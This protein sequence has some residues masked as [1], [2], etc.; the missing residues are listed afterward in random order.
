MAPERLGDCLKN[1][2][3]M[4]NN[5]CE[6]ADSPQFSFPMFSTR[7]KRRC[8]LACL[9]MSGLLGIAIAQES[10]PVQEPATTQEPASTQQQSTAP[11]PATTQEPAAA[12]EQPAAPEAA[13]PQES[14]TPAQP[15]TAQEPSAALAPAAA[16]ETTPPSVESFE[17]PATTSGNDESAGFRFTYPVRDE[18]SNKLVT[19]QAQTAPA[20]AENTPALLDAPPRLRRSDTANLL[21]PKAPPAA[22]SGATTATT[23]KAPDIGEGIFERSPFRY[24]FAINEGYN[25]NVNTQQSNGVQSLYTLLSAGVAYDFGSS[26]LKLNTSLSAALAFYYNNNQLANNGLFP[27]VNWVLG[28]NYAATPRL[29]LSFSTV[30]SLLSQPN[31]TVAGAANTYQGSY[32]ISDSQLGAKYLWKPKLATETTYNPLLFYYLDPAE[33]GDMS[34]FEQTIG[35]QFIFLWKPTTSLVAEYRFN[36]RNYFIDSDLNSWGNYALLGADYTLNPRS[37]LS[38]RGGAEQRVN[39]NPYGG[40]SNGYIGP[41]GQLNMNYA[42]GKDTVLGLQARYGTTASGLTSYNQGQQLLLGLNV[43][44]QVTARIAANAFF[45]YQNNYYDQ[46]G[47]VVNGINYDPPSFSNNIFNTGVNVSYK[48]NRIWSALAGYTFSTLMSG[49]TQ[50]Q[51]DYNQSIVYIGTEV[52]L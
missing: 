19:E 24:S 50:Q 46:P 21:S 35:Q 27:T 32:I 1:W 48:I 51:A 4:G 36:T 37:S 13:A 22:I 23:A 12:Q 31:Y 52:D 11:D 10:A 42:P 49:N 17:K 26:R 3:V 8:A 28:A 25:S 9:L 43:A 41:F 34:R 47:A 7:L 30:T 14:S 29:D 5:S 20:S 39:Q 38:F 33:G 45:N 2:L 16:N 18:G 15:T 6:N 44:H 40:G